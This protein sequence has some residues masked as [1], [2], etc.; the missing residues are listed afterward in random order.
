[1]DMIPYYD[2]E[3]SYYYENIDSSNDNDYL[4]TIYIRSDYIRS[5]KTEKA[6]VKQKPKLYDQRKEVYY[7]LIQA[8]PNYAKPRPDD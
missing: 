1:M 4:I 3:S 2:T 6:I 5:E 7:I 8:C